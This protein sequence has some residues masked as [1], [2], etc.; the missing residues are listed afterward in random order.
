MHSSVEPSASI[1]IDLTRTIYCLPLPINQIQISI[2]G[3]SVR[4]QSP[5]G[6]GPGLS[7]MRQHTAITLQCSPRGRALALGIIELL[8]NMDFGEDEQAEK[9]DAEG[10]FDAEASNRNG[11]VDGPLTPFLGLLEPE[12]GHRPEGLWYK[13]LARGWR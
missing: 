1:H 4:T 2:K 11:I 13:N 8:A 7:A 6:I 5:R 9:L 10:L 3:M 12:D